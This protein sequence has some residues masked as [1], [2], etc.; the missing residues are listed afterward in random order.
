MSY[1]NQRAGAPVR[2]ERR[3]LIIVQNLLVPFERRAWLKCQALVSAG[4]RVAVVCP[5]GQERFLAR[6][7]G[8]GGATQTPTARARW[9]QDPDLR[10]S[11]W[12]VRD[13]TRQIWQL[14]T[15]ELWYRNVRSMGVAA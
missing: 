15:M 11:R 1:Q 5:E 7:R 13:N 6:I 8:H 12:V 3:V 9:W 10:T 14:L 4:C 2:V